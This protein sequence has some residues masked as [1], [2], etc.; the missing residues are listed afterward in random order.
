MDV[1]Q[2]RVHW[3]AL[4]LA[5]VKGSVHLFSPEILCDGGACWPNFTVGRYLARMGFGSR[6][7]QE[8]L[9][10][11]RCY[12]FAGGEGRNGLIMHPQL[13]ASRNSGNFF[14]GGDGKLSIEKT[15]LGSVGR[16]F[17]RYVR[18][19]PRGA[20]W[21][22]GGSPEEVSNRSRDHEMTCVLSPT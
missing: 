17:A 4:H 9:V 21:I 3:P 14:E 1:P 8:A 16:C 12:V 10:C 22:G 20:E 13:L 5:L 6:R 18:G 11:K 7:N 2:N 15:I 19:V